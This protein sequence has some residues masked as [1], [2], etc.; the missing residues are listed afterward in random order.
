ML[1]IVQ[2]TIRI[3]GLLNVYTQVFI[4]HSYLSYVAGYVLG[5]FFFWFNR[6]FKKAK[7][8]DES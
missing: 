8:N 6:H 5:Y 2:C 1:M 3:N 4:V 7:I